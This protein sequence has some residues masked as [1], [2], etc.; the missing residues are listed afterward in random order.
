[1]RWCNAIVES[2]VRTS[3]GSISSVTMRL[4][5]EGDFKL[6]KKKIH[7]VS[8]TEPLTPVSVVLREFDHIITK[9]KPEEDDKIEE[10]CNTNSIQ[11]TE[12]LA[13][14]AVSSM[15]EGKTSLWCNITNTDL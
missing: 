12:A 2:I 6:T 5:P 11:D 1:M 3:N 7:W 15:K 9:K 13:D 4:N 14:P 8:K 10:I